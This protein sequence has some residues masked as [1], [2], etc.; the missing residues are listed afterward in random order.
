MRLNSA[1]FVLTDFYLV[2]TVEQ[3]ALLYSLKPPTPEEEISSNNHQATEARAST[4]PQ[5]WMFLTRQINIVHL[6]IRCQLF[7][8]ESPAD[9]IS[10]LLL[11]MKVSPFLCWKERGIM[12]SVVGICRAE[13][14]QKVQDGS[15]R[16]PHGSL[17]GSQHSA[18]L[19]TNAKS[20]AEFGKAERD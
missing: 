1:E 16:R 4:C 18:P 19:S 11:V 13:M 14:M 15:V 20:A 5:M 10:G 12:G 3:Q 8:F 7:S 6:P 17:H 9:V 2:P